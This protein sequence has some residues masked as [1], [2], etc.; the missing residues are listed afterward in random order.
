MI[1]NDD[2]ELVE[3]PDCKIKLE[4]SRFCQVCDYEFEDYINLYPLKK[5]M[6]EAIELQGCNC[7]SCCH[8]T[9]S[10]QRY[11]DDISNKHKR[12][13]IR[14]EQFNKDKEVDKAKLLLE[15]CG[16]VIILENKQ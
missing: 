4:K 1:M 16:Y 2:Y 5:V 12:N 3:C 8:L 14:I 6:M 10:H 7:D 9:I 13:K 11:L 15:S